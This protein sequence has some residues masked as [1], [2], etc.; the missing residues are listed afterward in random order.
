MLDTS[1]RARRPRRCARTCSPVSGSPSRPPGRTGCFCRRRTRTPSRQ[2][3]PTTPP[4]CP[5]STT[6]PCSRTSRRRSVPRWP[7]MPAPRKISPHSP[8]WASVAATPRWAA[9][10]LSAS[11]RSTR[12]PSDPSPRPAHA[13]LSRRGRTAP[14]H[15]RRCPV[16]SRSSRSRTAA[17]RLG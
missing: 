11:A 12:A 9:A 16:S 15:S 10:K 8:R 6:S 4:R 1:T 5:A 7:V 14:Q 13:R 2:P 3:P 17:R